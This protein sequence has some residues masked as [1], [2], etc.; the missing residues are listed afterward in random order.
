M[1][2]Q[3]KIYAV[4]ELIG[5]RYKTGMSPEEFQNLF[6]NIVQTIGP[7]SDRIFKRPEDHRVTKLINTLTSNNPNS[8]RFS[9]KKLMTELTAL[10]LYTPSQHHI[11]TST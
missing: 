10:N 4:K 3:D 9:R 11:S 2:S 1:S 5:A 6:T 7:H 8:R